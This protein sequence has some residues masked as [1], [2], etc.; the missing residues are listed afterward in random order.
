V[1]PHAAAFLGSELGELGE[2]APARGPVALADVELPD[3]APLPPLGEVPLRTDREARV[4]HA[5]GRS[6]PDLVRL[7]TGRIAGAPDGVAY[8]RS[9]EEVAAIVRACA[10]DGVAVVPFGGGTSVVGGVEPLRGPH[11]AVLA[12]DLRDLD[13]LLDV[14]ARSQLAWL[15]P[16]LRGPAAE[17]LLGSRGLT[18]G[19]L[20]QSFEYATIGGFAATR[21]A[22]QAS[23]GYGRF[24]ELARGLRGVAPAGELDV[25]PRPPNAAGPDLREV[26]LGSEGTLAVLTAVAVRVRPKPAARRFEA[27]SL[28]DWPDGLEAFRRLAQDGVA[29]DV[30]RLSDLEETRISLAQAGDGTAVRALRGYR[31]LR[32]HATGCLAILGWD[33]DPDEIARRRSVARRVLHA[34]GGLGLGAAPARAWEHGRFEAPYLRDA[35]MARGVLAETLETATTWSGL[36]ALH[37]AVTAALRTAL[38]ARAI[39]MC[40]VSHLYP[41]G[42]SLYFTFLRRAPEGEELA[43][44]RAAKT[45]ACEAIAAQ[46]ATITHHHAVGT[47]HAPWMAAEK[48]EAGLALL[49]AAK[50]ELDPDGILNPGKLLPTS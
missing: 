29:P 1:P 23:T 27:F 44:W 20:P 10:A 35:L 47:D 39:V 49:R 26:L 19:H 3:A 28:P 2:L 31:M 30:A 50:R 8:P 17:A 9:A 24:D 45:A 22:G 34:H 18:L 33:G 37:G 14:D 43:L 41:T 48:G 15:E 5:A 6:Y 42:A 16:G 46:G 7:R 25:P 12:L 13:R 4:A 11:A 40:H 38:G 21:S 36:E 32:G